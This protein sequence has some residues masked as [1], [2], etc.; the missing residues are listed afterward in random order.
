MEGIGSNYPM[1]LDEIGEC[2]GVTRKRIRQ[3]EYKALAK[4]RSYEKAKK[5]RMEK[6]KK[7]H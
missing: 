2:N 5:N 3:I 4:I 1:T 6:V 7:R